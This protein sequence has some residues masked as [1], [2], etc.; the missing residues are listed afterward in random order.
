MYETFYFNFISAV[1]RQR[2]EDLASAAIQAGAVTH[3]SK[4]NSS[5]EIGHTVILSIS[6]LV[7]LY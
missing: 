4:V 2:L 1:P 3:V 7:Q 5:H 6:S